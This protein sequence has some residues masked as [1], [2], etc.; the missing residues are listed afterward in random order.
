LL[1]PQSKLAC[2]QRQGK[3]VN[4]E[5]I[6]LHHI[7]RSLDIL[8]EAK[9]GIETQ[10]FDR[11]R[12]LFNIQIDIVFYD[13]TTYHFESVHSDSL[14]DFGFSKAGKYNEVQVVMGLLID[15]EGHPIGYDLFP[16]DTFEGNTLVTVLNGLRD[17]FSIRKIIIVA[18][19]GINSKK[20]FHFIKAAGYEYIVS[21]RLK[22]SSKELRQ[23]IFT[24]ENYICLERDSGG[25]PVFKYKVINDYRVNYRDDQGHRHQIF[26][27]L[28][29]TWSSKKA[30]KDVMDR[31]RQIEK[32]KKMLAVRKKPTTKK[33]YQKY[34]ALS[35]E[36]EVVGIDENRIAEDSI[37][38]GYYG[39]H[40]S[41]RTLDA[42]SVIDAYHQLWRIEESF[43]ILKSTMKT[44]PIFHWTPK[45][46]KGHFVVCFLSF[47]LERALEQKLKNNHV[48]VSPERLKEAIGSLEVTEIE[49]GDEQYYLK[50]KQLP[51]A[52]KIL[53]TLR[54]KH[55]KNV[56]P[57]EDFCLINTH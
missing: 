30:K 25:H 45:R 46:I 16:G 19:K 52:S 15:M 7:Y 53:N 29:I 13:V 6:P 42:K 37:W 11:Y 9:Q 56:T 41:D 32:A 14:K 26:N 12:N 27:N 47:V 5:D 33:G 4:I 28:V 22:T 35:G 10:L 1:T 3:Y 24:E 34:I 18:D 2:F 23:K 54:I 50:S 36:T 31:A 44:R 55:L 38:D 39:I 21:A 43:R 49:I 20:N 17:R 57:K 8:S 48:D 40:T 51:L